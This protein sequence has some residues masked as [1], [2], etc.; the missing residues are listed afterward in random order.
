MPPATP[1]PGRT[2]DLR[3]DHVSGIA[4]VLFGLVAILLGLVLGW[5]W[6]RNFWFRVGHLAAIGVVA[7]QALAG[8]I[9]PL[10]VLETAE[11]VSIRPEPEQTL[12]LIRGLPGQAGLVDPDQFVLFPGLA[13]RGRYKLRPHVLP[14]PLS[15]SRIG[16]R[17]DGR[18]RQV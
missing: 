11:K 14:N 8:L 2:F 5:P 17:P 9:C 10:T 12:A 16:E 13:D 7:G 18:I 15:L 6:V 4:F 3:A 1:E